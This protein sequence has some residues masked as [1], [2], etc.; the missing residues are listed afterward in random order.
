MADGVT[1]GHAQLL[2]ERG[3]QQDAWGG[4][5]D[6]SRPGGVVAVVADGIGGHAHGGDA[7]EVAVQTFQRVYLAAAR[8]ASIPEALGT[9]LRK[10]NAAVCEFADIQGQ[11]GNCGTTL[12]AAAL[13]SRS[14]SLH[15]ISVGDSRLYLQR[16]GEL[17]QL[18]VDG[19]Y[20]H[21][22]ARKVVRGT[23]ADEDNSSA[24]SL[25]TLTSFLGVA[26]L[27]YIDRNIRPF[28][29]HPGDLLVLCTDGLFGSLGEEEMAACLRGGAQAACDALIRAVAAKGLK[30][31]DNTTVV[32]LGF[33]V[34]D[35]P[36]QEDPTAKPGTLSALRRWL[37]AWRA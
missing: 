12:V 30:T 7:S 11:A 22:L 13:D 27:S 20:A 15:W 28:R 10:A 24:A 33:G 16:G 32:V 3:E 4:G 29:V 1:I 19:N 18:T 5:G 37:G 6:E 17:A 21:Q 35:A 31:Q 9:A 25:Q 36:T 8:Q 34:E 26:K 2:G 23:L 14:R